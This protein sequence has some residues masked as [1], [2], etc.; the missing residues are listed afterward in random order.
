MCGARRHWLTI[1]KQKAV[2]LTKP[3]LKRLGELH[4]LV[5]VG[6]I[7]LAESG[8]ALPRAGSRR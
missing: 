7:G 5:V 2:S 6:H 4:G 3:Y 1:R 8:E